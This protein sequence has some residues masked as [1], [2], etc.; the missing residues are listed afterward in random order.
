[1]QTAHDQILVPRMRLGPGNENDIKLIF[2][3]MPSLQIL[4]SPNRVMR[5]CLQSPSKYEVCLAGEKF[6]YLSHVKENLLLA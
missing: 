5:I 1:M 6:K 3:T 4:R 2:G